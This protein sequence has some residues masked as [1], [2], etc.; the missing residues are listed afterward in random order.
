MVITFDATV[1]G[2]MRQWI[3]D[4]I[5][6]SNYPFTS[7]GVTVNYVV[8]AEPPCPGHKD[9][10]CTTD[11]GA[12]MFTTHIRDGIDSPTGAIA[13]GLP[14][15]AQDIKIFFQETIMHELGHVIHFTSLISDDLITTV[16]GY[17]SRNGAIGE[18]LVVGEL[19][20][21]DGLS[22]PWEDRIEE[23]VAETIKDAALDSVHRI[24]DNRTN[25]D[26]N[27]ADFDTF[28]SLMSPS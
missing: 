26:I 25:W 24:Y 4:T 21:W 22:E 18:G 2:Q 11:E 17:F 19:A 16:T 6:R 23:A 13:L 10:M 9:M 20:D 3:N 28:T 14:N 7:L 5:A 12:G 8:V 1:T 27:R 15:P